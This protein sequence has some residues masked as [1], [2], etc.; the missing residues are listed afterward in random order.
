MKKLLASALLPFLASCSSG[1][2]LHWSGGSTGSVTLLRA[3]GGEGSLG[4]GS[5]P[6]G[7]ELYPGELVHVS[8]LAPG[9]ALLTTE[10]VL[11][12]GEA[13]SIP[14][15]AQYGVVALDPPRDFGRFN[16]GGSWSKPTPFPFRALTLEPIDERYV[17][18][19][20]FHAL[21]TSRPEADELARKFL[22]QRVRDTPPAGV[23]V[24]AHVYVV[25]GARALFVTLLSI[26]GPTWVSLRVDS[27]SHSGLP[28]TTLQHLGPWTAVTIRVPFTSLSTPTGGG[29]I[30]AAFHVDRHRA[31][32]VD[33]SFTLELPPR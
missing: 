7:S 12:N 31:T 25:M 13:A 16:Y 33:G 2:I 22:G 9:A 20:D 14:F 30:E 15:G 28:G 21:A 18:F 32:P 23:T 24:G 10:D 11:A 5:G 17:R 3:A 26:P 29:A 27:F 1:H 8:F 6:I 19:V 4:V